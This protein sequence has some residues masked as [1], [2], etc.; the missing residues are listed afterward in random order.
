MA[1]AFFT[2][3]DGTWFQPTG[4]CRG[5]WDP[6]ACHAGPPTGLLARASERLVPDQ[7]LV[8]LS[9]DLT[10]P[11]PHAGFSIGA[12]VTR[13]GRTVSTTE[14]ELLDGTGKRIVVGRGMHLAPTQIGALPT[15]PY[16]TPDFSEARSDR[17]PITKITH[18]LEAFSSGTEVRYPP[19]DTPDPGPTRVWMRALPLLADEEPS[20]FQRICPLADC[21]N[22]F[23]RNAEP[24]E[25]AF[26]NTDLTIV[27]HRTPVGEWLGMDAVSRWEPTGLG[28]SDALLFDAHG[29]VGRAVQSRIIQRLTGG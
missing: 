3:D 21:G 17:F 9:V 10:R 11:V 16:P 12:R 19:G 7:Q 2:T 22:A 29:A 25:L 5:P 8:R 24:G 26:M 28:M 23:S 14:M 15:A 27:L 1:D 4:P 18:D 6:D 13:A 20:G